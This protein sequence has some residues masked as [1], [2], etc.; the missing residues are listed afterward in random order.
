MLKTEW[1]KSALASYEESLKR[2][3]DLLDDPEFV[4]TSEMMNTYRKLNPQEKKI[5]R[6]LAEYLAERPTAKKG[7]WTK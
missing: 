3:E 5:V 6:D 1:A 2:T 4:D 7:R